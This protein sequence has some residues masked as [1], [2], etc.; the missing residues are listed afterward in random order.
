MANKKCACEEE[1]PCITQDC[2]CEVFIS[3]DCVTL[4]EDLVCSNI[5]K[6]LTET[7]VLKQL[8]AYI[9]ERF[10]SVENFLDIVNVGGGVGIYKGISVIGKKEL[11][12]LLSDG[13]VSII[14]NSDTITFSINQDNFVRQIIINENDLP[15][16]YTTQDVIDYVLLLPTSER[17]ILSTD[18]KFNIIIYQTSS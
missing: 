5:P 18:S 4:S 15:I 7:E 8:D 9:C 12:S 16:N 11:R 2:A 14:Q 13:T 1:I 3:T 17:T 6:G 10:Q